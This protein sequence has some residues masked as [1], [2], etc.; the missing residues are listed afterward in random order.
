MS[1]EVASLNDFKLLNIKCKRYFE[2][3]SKGASF[4]QKPENEKLKERFGFY[5]FMLE[6]L[7]DE[8]DLDRISD[9]I[10]DTEYNSYLSNKRHKDQGIDAIYINDES[11]DISLFNF[12]FRESF[13]PNKKQSNNEAFIST[14]IVNCILNSDSSGLE[15]KLKKL[16][17]DAIERLNS[18][19]VWKI[20]LYMLSNESEPIDIDETSIQQLKDFYDMEVSSICLPQ[21]KAMMSIRPKPISSELIIDNDALMS[22][23]ENTISTSKSYIVRLNAADIIRITCKT[24]EVRNNYNCEKIETL[25]KEHIDYGVLFDNVRGFVQKSKYNEAIAKSLREEPS[26]F[27]MYNNG[28]T[29]VAKDIKAEPVNGNKKVRI[30]I[31]DF[32]VLNG[33]QTLRTLHNFNAKDES[34]ITEYLSKSEVLVR[35]FN[36]SN[37]D[38]VNKIAEYTNSQ[39]S[40]SN[41]DLKSLS[42]LQI[43]LEQL[44]DE[45]GIIYSRKNGDTGMDDQKEYRYKISME[46]FG[47]ILFAI[48]GNPEKSSNQKQHIFGKYYD[49]IFSAEKFNISDA[50]MI[51]ENYFNIKKSYDS[52][53]ENLQKIEQKVFYIL[54]MQKAG[55]NLT[56]Q[57]CIEE[58]EKA[59]KEFKS[60]EL[61]LT[62]ARK[63]IQVRFKDFLNDRLGL[64]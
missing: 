18:N 32:Q 15:G 5:L 11:K 50:P 3:Y 43:Q 26:K 24:P 51:I 36:A 7:C 42:T 25:A 58:L 9:I 14:K 13:K 47:Q 44:L 54:Y 17:D 49:E 60:S 46:L 52:I 10:T 1:E 23:S 31:N 12:K 33:G 27:F 2:L 48:Q 59:L 6:N 34:N 57:E 38:A 40:I 28:M 63:M 21:I 56:C 29:I 16:V 30:S 41:V 22:Y 64:A 55:T 20:S 19:D 4:C 53:S 39:N 37:S 35:I 45:H 62:D 61:K 8:K